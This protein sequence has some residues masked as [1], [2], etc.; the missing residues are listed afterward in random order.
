MTFRGTQLLRLLSATSHAP[1]AW[2]MM[3]ADSRPLLA[4]SGTRLALPYACSRSRRVFTLARCQR[5]GHTVFCSRSSDFYSYSTL[6]RQQVTTSPRSRSGSTCGCAAIAPT[7]LV[8]HDR[9]TRHTLSSD[10][11]REYT[12]VRDRGNSARLHTIRKSR[13][14]AHQKTSKKNTYCAAHMR[15][16]VP[17]GLYS[18]P[19]LVARVDVNH[20]T[21]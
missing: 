7:H 8:T 12:P 11:T 13:A 16:G 18:W 14:L 4:S 9:Q 10:Q 21:V 1:Y 20:K 19:L 6:P 2:I 17:R 3:H 5:F 15:R